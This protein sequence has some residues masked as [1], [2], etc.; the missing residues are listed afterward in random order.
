VRR[1]RDELLGVVSKLEEELTSLR[2]AVA[3]SSE[4]A[5]KETAAAA[6]AE[7]LQAE[8]LQAKALQAQAEETTE[9][10]QS[11]VARLEREA[12]AAKET[13][14]AVARACDRLSALAAS[15]NAKAASGTRLT[16][17]V[18]HV[19][20]MHHRTQRQMMQLSRRPELPEEVGE[21]KKIKDAARTNC[22]S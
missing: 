2:A 9:A 11:Q 6:A 12:A 22:I 16:Q 10:L 5:E 7:T 4:T 1:E 21:K 15:V 19:D 14:S 3:H 17:L 18:E 8:A 13:D 20:A